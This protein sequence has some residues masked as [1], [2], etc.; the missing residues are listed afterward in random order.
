ME[1]VSKS[2]WNT[3]SSIEDPERE[4]KILADVAVKARELGLSPQWVQH[5][6]RLQMEASKQ[7]QYQLFAEWHETSQAQF[8]EVLDLKTAIRPRLDSLDDK[9]LAA[10][11]ANWSTLSLRGA[12]QQLQG[13]EVPTKFPKAMAF[14]LTPLTDRSSETTGIAPAS[15]R[16]KP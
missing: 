3:K 7:V 13:C 5:F 2:K 12:N 6:F 10:M 1:Q 15:T 14:A 4:Q 16:A 8:P 11:K 9:I